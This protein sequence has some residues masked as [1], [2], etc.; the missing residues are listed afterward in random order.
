MQ[1]EGWRRYGGAFTFGPV[2][3][4]QCKNEAVVI[5]G[6]VQ[7]GKTD[8]YPSCRVC[9]QECIDNGIKINS[10][11]LAPNTVDEK[12]TCPSCD[13]EGIYDVD[14]PAQVTCQVCGGSGQ[15]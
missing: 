2:R 1:C 13:S 10:S 8:E 6:V 5:L 4:E 3:W 12:H 11:R 7:D 14:N 9:W 15:V